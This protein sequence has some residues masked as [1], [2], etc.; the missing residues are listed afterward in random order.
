[1]K[2]ETAKVEPLALE[3]L[4]DQCTRAVAAEAELRHAAAGHGPLQELGT[5]PAQG[6]IQMVLSV[7]AMDREVV[8]GVEAQPLKDA[9]ELVLAFGKAQTWQEFAGCHPSTF[10]NGGTVVESFSEKPL[11][12][13]IGRG[14]F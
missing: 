9:V 12:W 3:C 13:S 2:V 4:F 1:M 10:G 14:G 6:P 11:C 7:D 8:E 5:V